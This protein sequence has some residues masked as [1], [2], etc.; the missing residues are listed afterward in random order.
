[1]FALKSA[2]VLPPH[3]HAYSRRI[4][5]LTFSLNLSLDG[6]VDHQA[7]IDDDETHALF[8]RLM[9]TEGWRAVQG[10]GPTI[11]STA[12]FTKTPTTDF[13]PLRTWRVR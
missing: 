8:T 9:D 10:L 1:M 7:G 13:G 5:L 3:F 4:G 6:C 2:R 12:R 11:G